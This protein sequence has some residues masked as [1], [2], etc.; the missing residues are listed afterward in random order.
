MGRQPFG[1]ASPAAWLRQRGHAVICTDLAR[2]VFPVEAVNCAHL[3]AIYL[4]MHTATRI[5]LKAIQCIRTLNPLAHL[6]CYGLY[7]PMNE[8]YLRGLGVSTII[9]GEF[10]QA[11]ADLADGHEPASP[12]SLE[13]LQFIPPDR[14]G[15]P[16]LSRYA[17]LSVNGESRLAGYTEASRGCKHLCR[18]C[19]IVPVYQG[20]FRVVQRETVQADVRAQVEAGARHITFGDPDFF[21]GPGHARAVVESLHSEFPDITYDVTIKVEHLL[22][23]VDLLPVLKGTGCLFVVSAVESVDDRVLEILDKGHT[24]TDFLRVVDLMREVGLTLTPTFVPFTPWTTWDTYRDLLKT[25]A[26]LDL[27]CNVS[28]I[29]LAIRLLIPE[30]SRLLEIDELREGLEGFDAAA[31]TYR[32]SNPDASLD[33]LV[34]RLQSM[35]QCQEKAGASR[36]VIF[37]QIW[38]AAFAEPMTYDPALV[39]RAAIPFLTEPWYC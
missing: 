14:S 23:H 8:S 4:P 1:L 15:M 28:P 24:R 7:A 13:R 39:A 38:Q 9:G 29:Q 31:L 6:C 10:E 11:L 18:H 35:I 20:T 30:G 32:W 34:P 2:E 21:N 12:V 3:V 36:T 19:P 22:K 27:V 17:K 16:P 5:A 33:A 26:D 25:I 37:E